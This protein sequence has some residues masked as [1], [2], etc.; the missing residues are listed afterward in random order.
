M[1]DHW[2]PMPAQPLLG[3]GPAVTPLIAVEREGFWSACRARFIN[4]GKKSP[5]PAAP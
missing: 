2:E 5:D 3:R 4:T 1:A